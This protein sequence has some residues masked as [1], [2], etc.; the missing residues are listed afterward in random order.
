MCSVVEKRLTRVDL[1]L[2]VERSCA[3][4][5]KIYVTQKCALNSLVPKEKCHFPVT[6]LVGKSW[7][8]ES[9]SDHLGCW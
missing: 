1:Y 2:K 9:H 4:H 6:S 3:K 8:N 7:M 5:L